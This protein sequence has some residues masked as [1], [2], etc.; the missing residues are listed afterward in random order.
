MTTIRTL[1][2]AD[3][4]NLFARTAIGAENLLDNYLL[5]SRAESN[6]PPYDI[7]QLSSDDYRITLAVAG[8]SKDELEVRIDNGNLI[9]TG[10]HT[11]V[12]PDPNEEIPAINYPI[13]LHKGIAKRD[14]SRTFKL[15]EYVLVSDVA[16]R[17]GL[18]VINLTRELP[19]ALK[20]RTIDI[21]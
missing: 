18:L 7:E 2:S 5:P 3:I 10:Q 1:S 9:V 13:A 14:F 12:D 8:F 17:D 19:E 16:L 11:V 20:P 6:F 4:Q 15:M 21:A